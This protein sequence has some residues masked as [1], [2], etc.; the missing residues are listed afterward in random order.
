VPG[1]HKRWVEE[2]IIWLSSEKGFKTIH[3]SNFRSDFMEIKLLR[4]IPSNPFQISGDFVEYGVVLFEGGL[5]VFPATTGNPGL[6]T[7][8]YAEKIQPTLAGNLGVQIYS[9]R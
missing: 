1:I 3:E 5:Q 6:Q 4:V 8:Q 9:N 2:N 7:H